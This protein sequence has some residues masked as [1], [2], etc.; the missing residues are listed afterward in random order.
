[1]ASVDRCRTV[2]SCLQNPRPA[3]PSPQSLSP[4]FAQVPLCQRCRGAIGAPRRPTSCCT[5]AAELAF[6]GINP[7]G[8]RLLGGYPRQH[9]QVV[10]HACALRLHQ[11]HSAVVVGAALQQQCGMKPVSRAA[12]AMRSAL[13][14]PAR[15]GCGSGWRGRRSPA[16]A[17]AA[18]P[19]QLPP[20]RDTRT[21]PGR[22]RDRPAARSSPACTCKDGWWSRS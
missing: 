4:C 6:L 3:H 13:T 19:P 20:S 12:A 14:A 9:Q 18:A 7:V 1:M 21:G 5:E 15:A 10:Q 17:A 2:V 11:A 22:R 8:Q 16:G